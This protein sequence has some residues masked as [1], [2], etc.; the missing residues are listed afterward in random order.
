MD[1]KRNV[2]LAHFQLRYLLASTSRTRIFYPGV[3]SVHQFNPISRET[4][5]I[6]KTGDTPGS[7]VS[8]IACDYGVL[9][10]GCFNGD[11]NLRHLDTPETGN[12][13]CRTGNITTDPSGITNHIQI[14]Q[15]RSSSSPA[16]AFSSN[17]NAVRVLDIETEKWIS[18]EKFDFA[19]NCTATSPDKRLRAVVGDNLQLLITAAE[20]T[21]PD[22]KPEVFYNLSGHRDYGFAVDWADDGWTIASAFQDKTVKI[23]DARCLTDSS[24]NSKTVTTIRTEMAGARNLRFSPVGSG[25]RV[26]VAAEEADYVNVIDAQTFRTKQTI[27]FFGEIGGVTFANEGEDLLV[28]CCDPDRGGILQF[29]RC[30]AG[31]NTLEYEDW[32]GDGLDWPKSR[33]TEDRMANGGR[34]GRGLEGRAWAGCDIEPF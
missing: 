15:R 3:H 24:G 13:A 8:A 12:K 11:Y 9:V 6:I 22:N 30:G 1:I 20:S 14:H 28:L 23:W 19:I 21:L 18:Q 26:L 25:R 29:E 4:R 34:A 16:A 27:D 17:D 10:A 2:N 33:F 31:G 5:P 32:V 7:Q